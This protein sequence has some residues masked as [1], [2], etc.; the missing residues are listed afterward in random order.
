MRC[1]LP[2]RRLVLI[3]MHTM[4]I[5]FPKLTFIRLVRATGLPPP[6]FADSSCVMLPTCAH[7]QNST[8]STDFHAS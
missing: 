7:N 8:T 3:E 1:F 6:T 2:S 4:S 5:F